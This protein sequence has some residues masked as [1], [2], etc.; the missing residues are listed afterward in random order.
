MPHHN[1][2]LV[3]VVQLV[4]CLS[5]A[6][7]QFPP[8]RGGGRGVLWIANLHQQVTRGLIASTYGQWAL[9]IETAARSTTMAAIG[10]DDA[11]LGNLP[12][13]QVKRHDRVRQVGV[14]PPVSFNHHFLHNIAGVDAAF[15]A[16]VHAQAD[17]PMDRLP[18]AI[19]QL[20]YRPR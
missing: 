1:D 15:Q 18:M 10:I 20:A 3:L 17:Q 19:E 12:E 9:A 4:A 5:K 6:S 16:P 2:F 11:V 13:P 7:A 14:Q 8:N